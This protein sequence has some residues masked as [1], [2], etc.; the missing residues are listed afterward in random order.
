MLFVTHIKPVACVLVHTHATT[1]IK[2][3]R[4]VK[5]FDQTYLPDSVCANFVNHIAKVLQDSLIQ[6][7]TLPLRQTMEPF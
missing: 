3:K 2:W 5:E 7:M 6:T 1:H 4:S